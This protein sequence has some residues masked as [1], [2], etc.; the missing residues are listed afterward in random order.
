MAYSYE[1]QKKYFKTQAGKDAHKRYEISEKGHASNRNRRARN[2]ALH[3]EEDNVRFKEHYQQNKD[4]HKEKNRK[5]YE[6]NGEKW[7]ARRAEICQEWNYSKCSPYFVTSVLEDLGTLLTVEEEM[8]F[9]QLCALI[10]VLGY[11]LEDVEY[12]PFINRYKYFKET[13]KVDWL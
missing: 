6:E 13:K 11:N 8:S 10:K 9:S 4:Y 2:H 7:K 5:H 12:P 1:Y 3:R